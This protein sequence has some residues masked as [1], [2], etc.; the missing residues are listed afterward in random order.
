M[1]FWQKGMIFLARNKS[2]TT[3]MQNRASLSA[4]ATSFVGGRNTTDAI[5]KARTLRSQGYHASLFYLGEYVEDPAVI[6]RTVDALKDVAAGLGREGM[7]VHISVDP[8][9][10]G[11]QIDKKI[12]SD[13]AFEIAGEIKKVISGR[14]GPQKKF[15]MLDMEDSSVTEATISLYESLRKESMRMAITLQAYLYRTK[16][17]LEKI[18]KVGGVVR[19]VK[20]AFAESADK[21]F[22]K[23]TDIYGNYLSL[24]GIMLSSEARRSGFYPIFG[25]HDDRLIDALIELASGK[26]WKKGE[27]EFE[28]LYGVRTDLQ[29]RLVQ[30]GESLRLYLP[31]GTDWWP[32]AIRRVGESPKNFKFLLRLLFSASK[33]L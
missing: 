23:R 17:D 20:G 8:T 10:I 13:N 22:T 12:C 6:H 27:Y 1:R 26:G 14:I 4:L 9:Q 32:Y 7:D 29:K 30:R 16:R 25:T 24:A 3:F 2:V 18:V 5:E 11:Y 31:F 21:A 33:Q 15:L 19:L 28:M